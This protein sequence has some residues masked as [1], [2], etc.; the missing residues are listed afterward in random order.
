MNTRTTPRSNFNNQR[1][2]LVITGAS[3]GPPSSH[4]VGSVPPITNAPTMIWEDSGVGAAQQQP[5]DLAR[6][7]M[8]LPMSRS[9]CRA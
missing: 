6:I 8:M 4:R 1:D 3:N 7:E 9:G 2:I 5:L